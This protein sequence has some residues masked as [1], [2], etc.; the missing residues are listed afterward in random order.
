MGLGIYS[1]DRDRGGFVETSHR[2]Q[3]HYPRASSL[4]AWTQAALV[5]LG[6]ADAGDVL[7][8]A[9]AMAQRA[10]QRDAEDPW[11]H[12]AAGYVHMV[13]RDF[14]EAVK[15]LTEAIELNPSFGSLTW[16]LERS[17]AMAACRR[18]AC[19]IVSSG[20]G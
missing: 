13:S 18:M 6:W 2:D 4:L 14:D 1:G 11:S 3:S 16:Y 5:Q 10:I 19:T 9:R 12:L 20:H 15:E 17:T 7:G 8:N